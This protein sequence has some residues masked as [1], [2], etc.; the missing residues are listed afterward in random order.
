MSE[1]ASVRF[2][3]T[4]IEYEVRRSKRRRKTVQIRWTAAACRLPRL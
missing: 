2:G 3:N 1:R 4:T